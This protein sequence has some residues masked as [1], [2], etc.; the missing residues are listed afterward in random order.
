MNLLARINR[1]LGGD[2]DLDA[3]APPR[4][5]ERRREPHRDAPGEP[6]RPERAAW[7]AAA[8]ASRRA[9]PSTR[10]N[11]YKFTV[12]GFADLAARAGWRVGA[13]WVSPDPAFAVFLL[14]AW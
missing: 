6:A 2:F 1:E 8:S 7:P 10:E 9:R 14:Q 3:F 5:L 13:Q 4:R 11:S 12:E